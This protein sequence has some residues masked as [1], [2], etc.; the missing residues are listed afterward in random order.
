MSL[1][2]V[3]DARS[4]SNDQIYHAANVLGKSDDRKKVFLAIYSGKKRVKTVKEIMQ[5]TGM[6]NIRVLQEGK[7][8]AANQIVQAIKVGRQTAYVKD[9]FLGEHRSR[10]LSHAGN[11]EKLSSFPTKINPRSVGKTAISLKIFGNNV[12]TTQIHVDDVD[13]F[14]KVRRIHK[15]VPHRQISEEKFKK[16]IQRIIGE[17]GKFI[18]W[19]GERNDLYST[20][21]MLKGKRITTAFAFKG[22]GKKVAKLTPAHMGKNG[23]QIQRLFSCSAELFIVQYWGQI[24]ESIVEQMKT[25]AA[26]KSIS[27]RKK[28]Y[29][30][31]IDGKDSARLILA[32]RSCFG[33]N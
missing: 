17:R 6:S 22:K 12:I 27:E 3:T 26:F 31:V 18:D 15:E 8:L 23:D 13:S 29:F 16:G 10:I 9:Q 28:I 33:L 14:G 32:Y 5:V 30:C 4:N 2:H 24:D 20:R 19:G 21:V 25:F 11:S 1:Q 7:R